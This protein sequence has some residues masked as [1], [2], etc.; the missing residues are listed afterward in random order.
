MVK[1]TGRA[2]VKTT[3]LFCLFPLV[4]SEF[5]SVSQLGLTIICAIIAVVFDLI[6]LPKMINNLK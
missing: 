2:V 1:T 4:F 3:L 6:Y 5:K